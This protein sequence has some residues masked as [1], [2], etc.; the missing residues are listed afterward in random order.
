MLYSLSAATKELLAL[1]QPA[2]AP[3]QEAAAWA[4]A[5]C[6]KVRDP[7]QCQERL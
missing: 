5:A 7:W 3:L 1:R 2:L 4:S 6:S